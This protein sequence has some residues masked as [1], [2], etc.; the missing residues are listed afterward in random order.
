[1]NFILCNFGNYS[2]FSEPQFAH[3]RNGDDSLF[4]LT[5]KGCA[6]IKQHNGIGMFIHLETLSTF[7]QDDQELP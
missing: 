5:C 2:T 4:C 1:M 3:L 6:A 7:L